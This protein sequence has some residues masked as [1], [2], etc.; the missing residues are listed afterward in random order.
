MAAPEARFALA[1]DQPALTVD[2]DWT[3]LDDTPNLVAGYQIDRG[4]QYELDK[5]DTGRA[6]VTINDIDGVLDPTNPTGPYTGSIVPLTPAII[7]RR[8]PVTDT[9]HT[10]YRG[11]VEDYQY[12]FDP[13]Q[14]FNRLTLTLVDIFEILSVMEFTPGNF[15]QTP[16]TDP[17]L[18]ADSAGQ[19]WYPNQTMKDRVE[20]ILGNAGIPDDLA[21][22]FTGNVRVQG[23][24][25]SPGESVM[26][27]IQ[28]A[29]D[30]E[31]PGGPSNVYTD[32]FGRLA[33]HGRLAKF[34]PVGTY[35]SAD[36][37][38]W[39]F[40]Q[41]KA[42]DG[43]A[44]VAHPSTTAQ[45]RQFGFNRG[46]SK[47]INSALSTPKGIADSAVQ[48]QLVQDLDSIGR[49]GI[50]SWSAQN[51]IT[52]TGILDDADALEETFKYAQ[53]MVA[54]YATPKD[55][56]TTIGFRS[57]GL[58]APGAAATWALLSDVDIADTIQVTVGS[59]G[60]GGFDL[61][62]YFVEGV[63]EQ[64]QPLGTGY[65]DVT[66]TLDLSPRAY[67]TDLSMFPEAS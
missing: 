40:N 65:D 26:G 19:V 11:F 66:L 62:P 24:V 25:F 4:R 30:A 13:S 57:I 47:V 16:T 58:G 59:P 35:E 60:G 33:I 5:T 28:E 20:A 50:R 37:G 7:R 1:F 53:Y 23:T 31:F 36:P 38:T 10:R 63:H 34:D 21:I 49:Y 54:N 22:V 43:A 15:G 32:K 56:I 67:F 3:P 9:W 44:V 17:P 55:R 12:E 51:L 52:S 41:W 29:V 27:G 2:P 64:A 46:L 45:I 18:P 14:R 6:T 39:D 61:E 42:G 8:N 48:D